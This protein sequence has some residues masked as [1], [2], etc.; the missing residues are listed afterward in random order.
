MRKHIKKY[1]LLFIGFLSVI[2]GLI[3]VVLPILPTTPFLILALACF[4]KSSPRFHQMLLHN[5][6]F[7]ATL[8]QWEESKT[9]DHKSKI[10]AIMLIILT[11]M[12]S[13][14]VLYE[15]PH[16]QAGLLI[17]GGILLTFIW[18]LKESNTPT[19]LP[20]KKQPPNSNH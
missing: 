1:S 7:G 6:W 15:K 12:T 9:I 20:T 5:P 10:K 17:L 11:F 2:L 3:G 16:L 8:Q 18:R 4:A 14:A 19:T 13:I